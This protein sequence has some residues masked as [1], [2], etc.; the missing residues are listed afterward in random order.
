MAKKYL[1]YIHA[2]QFAK[3]A[4][5]SALVNSLLTEYYASKK[6]A[7]LKQTIGAMSVCKKGHLYKGNQCTNKECSNG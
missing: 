2:E 5:K 6:L 3:E 7:Q 4:H 1:L